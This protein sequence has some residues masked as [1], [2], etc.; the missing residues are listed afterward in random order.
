LNFLLG[1]S[2]KKYDPTIESKKL[3]E[4]DGRQF[5]IEILDLA[6]TDQFTAMYILLTD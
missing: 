5:M 3:V 4:V 6:G 1:T 2:L